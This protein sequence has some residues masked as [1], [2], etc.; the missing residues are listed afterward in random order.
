[1]RKLN[2][3]FLLF[4]VASVVLAGT[5]IFVLHWFQAGAIAQGLLG[6]AARAED[7]GGLAQAAKYL[8]RYLE[9]RPQDTAQRARL[10]EILANEKLAAPRRTREQALFLLEQVLLKEPERHDSRRILARLALA[11]GR[12]DLAQEHLK[13]LHQ[14]QPDD[15][16]LEQLQAG[17]HEA[18]GQLAEAAEWYRKA[19]RHAPRTLDNYVRLAELL[20]RLPDPSGRNAG[21]ADEVMNRLVTE[22]PQEFRAYLARWRHGKTRERA[23]AEDV[24]KALELAPDDADV[25]LAAAEVAQEQKDFKTARSH[26]ARGRDRHAQDARFYQALALVDLAQEQPAQAIAGLKKGVQELTGRGQ[27]D[28]LWTLANVLLDTRQL[29]EADAIVVQ[30]RALNPAPA[31]LDYLGARRLMLQGQWSEAA[32]A[33]ERTRPQLEAV[34]SLAQQVDQFLAQCYEQLAEPGRQLD[35]Y[36]RAVQANP[37]QVPARLR[38]IAAHE[39]A[40][41]V[42]EAILQYRELMKLTAAPAEGWIGLARQLTLRQAQRGQR[43]WK[44]AD[45]ALRRAEQ[46]GV[47]AGKVATARAELLVAQGKLAEARTLLD[48][49]RQDS[50]ALEIWIAS[51]ALAERAGKTQEV[52]KLL[53]EAVQRCGD[54][55]ELRL[56]RLAHAAESRDPAAATLLQQTEQALDQFQGAEHTRLLYGLAETHHRL[57]RREDAQRLWA[58]LAGLPAYQNDLRIRLFLFDL[59]LQ[60]GDDSAMASALAEIERLDG[61]QGPFRRYCEAARLLARARAGDR[62]G[63]DEARAHLDAVAAR[64]PNWPAAMLAK[65]ELEE[66]LN[67]PRQALTL[68]RRAHELGEHHPRFVRRLVELL[69]REQQYAEADRLLRTLQQQAP[70]T[71][72]L[73]RLAVDVSVRSGDPARALSMVSNMR[74]NESTDYKDHLW[75]GQV[76]AGTGQRAADAERHLRKA[77]ELAGEVPDT[78]VAL[79]RFLAGSGKKQDAEAL[80]ALV[81]TK[82]KPEQA[83]LTLAQCYDGLGQYEPARAQFQAAL[84]AQPDRVDVVRGAASFYLRWNRSKEAESLLRALVDGKVKASEADTAWARRGLAMVLATSGDFRQFPRALEMVGLRLDR[85]G[86]LD[87]ESLRGAGSNEERYAQARVL[88]TQPRRSFRARAVVLLEELGQRQGL[89]AE[90]QF[91]LSRLYDEEGTAASRAK[92]RDLL[93]RLAAAH[94]NQP[95]YLTQHALALLRQNQPDEAQQALDA[96]ARL[97]KSRNAA[98]GTFATPELRARLLEVR[99]QGAEAVRLLEENVTRNSGKVDKVLALVETLARLKRTREALDRCEAVWQTGPPELAAA[100]AVGV[101]RMAKPA[102]EDFTRVEQ[103][104]EAACAQQPSSIG[105]RM[106]L[107]RVYEMR[108]QFPKA[109]AVYRDVLGREPDNMVALNN[110]AWLLA[111]EPARGTEALTLIRRAID[112][113]GPMADL[114]DTRGTAYLSQGRADLA[115]ADLEAA[116]ADS[117]NPSGFFRL[118]RAQLQAN[119]RDAALNAFQKAKAA[120]LDPNKLHPAERLVYHQMVRDFEQ[121]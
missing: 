6:Q 112:R 82:V 77:V 102:A 44:E 36:R 18:Q 38:L 24:A 70:L 59:A 89:S 117:P 111:Q 40:G 119:R 25:L 41:R 103:R 47:S 12:A 73:Q 69:H 107:A 71:A 28:L 116:T 108:E 118:A 49:A 2:S 101:L 79:A 104:L 17:C 3:R 98:S 51:A 115:V 87:E 80:L 34:P 43:D 15:A 16:Q 64:R 76:L 33:L 72:D 121:R 39:A 4:L 21:E 55:V 97:E 84:A 27:L 75:L 37:T 57:G 53:D 10:A 66:L 88:A 62:T 114:L 95:T 110:L 96:L 93:R 8:G 32:R 52:P 109:E 5:G 120:G 81:K 61:V 60:A 42:E 67:N 1:M 92:A 85:D 56:A 54:R 14:A 13:V 100:A 113:A 19:V 22:N 94:P 83:L 9:F 50:Q 7:E 105:L 31:T 78:W 91:L 63:L 20:R 99:G 74:L 30:L 48:T 90:D 35:L 58:R 65:G 29:R 23:A 26:L 45:E 68:Y 86:N 46:A 11:L 106:H